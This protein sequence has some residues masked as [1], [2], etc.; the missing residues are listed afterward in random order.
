MQD[1]FQAKVMSGKLVVVDFYADW[2]GP[3]KTIAPKY[4]V[5]PKV[6]S[7]YNLSDLPLSKQKVRHTLA[8]PKKISYHAQN[9]KVGSMNFHEHAALHMP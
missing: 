2:C 7:R 8:A 4:E 9:K 1:D 5:S 6:T 3:C